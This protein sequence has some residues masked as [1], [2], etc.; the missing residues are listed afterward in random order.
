M[1]EPLADVVPLCRA[2]RHDDM[3]GVHCPHC[4]SPTGDEEW[5]VVLPFGPR[6]GSRQTRRSPANAR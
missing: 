1:P 6:T 3:P 5:A 2:V 4:A